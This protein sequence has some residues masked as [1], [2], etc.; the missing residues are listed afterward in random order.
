MRAIPWLL[1]TAW[2][3]KCS[4]EAASFTKASRHV[5][6][7]QVRLLLRTLWANRDTDFGRIHRFRDITDARTYQERVPLATYDDFAAGIR[8]VAAGEANV[9]TREPVRL[10]EPTG[11]TTGGEK[12]IPYTAG[13]RRQF[14]RGV[15]AWIADLFGRRP[16]VRKGRAYWSISPILGPPRR[17][18]RR[19]AHRL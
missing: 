18:S 1:N 3:L 2:M 19:A 10:L 15:A 8:R 4:S 12:L 14:Q 11:G 16:M 6:D 5:A 9:L 7:T 17:S 13:L